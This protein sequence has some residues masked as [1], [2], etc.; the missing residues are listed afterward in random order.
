MF[1]IF[2]GMVPENELLVRSRVT[3]VLQL[4]RLGGMLPAASNSSSP[5]MR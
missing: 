3:K 2:G 1:P 4:A 5:A